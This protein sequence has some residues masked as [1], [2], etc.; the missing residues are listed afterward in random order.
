ML[1]SS[2]MSASCRNSKEQGEVAWSPRRLFTVLCWIQGAYYFLTG[3]WPLVSVRT[4][5]LVTG[6]KG[7]TDNQQTGLDIDH[8]LLMTV[9]VLITAIG[10]A[11]LATAYRKSAPAEIA[12]LAIAAA[13]GLTGID[14]V[15]TQRDIILPVYLLDAVAQIALLFAWTGMLVW[16][17]RARLRRDSDSGRIRST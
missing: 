12:V 16:L 15:Y 11:L 8:W 17:H 14:I 10:L 2:D 4:F 3:V 6:E 1:D 5:K 13:I 9:S 7:K